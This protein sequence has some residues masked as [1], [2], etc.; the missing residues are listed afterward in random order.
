MKVH[1][2]HAAGDDP[3]ALSIQR[4]AQLSQFSKRVTCRLARSYGERDAIFR[5]RYQS[6]LRAGLISENSFGRYIEPADHVANAYLMG[7]Y[8]ERTGQFSATSDRYPNYPHLLVSRTIPPRFGA[9]P[10]KQQD[11]SRN[12]LRGY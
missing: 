3:A 8:F 4:I 10:K 6:Y 12:E 1:K 9:A 5:L 7:L 11:R 2:P